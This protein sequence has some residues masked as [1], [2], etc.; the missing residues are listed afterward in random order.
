[1]S[2]DKYAQEDVVKRA[3]I[4][5]ARAS[6][7]GVGAARASRGMWGH[8]P[9]GNVSFLGPRNAISHFSRDKFHKSKHEK[10]LT[11]Q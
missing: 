3:P 11:I 10:T 6:R 1:M 4:S 5:K 7:A 2:E 9:P 8:A